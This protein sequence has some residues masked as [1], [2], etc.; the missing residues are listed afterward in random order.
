MN[1]L[2]AHDLVR[3]RRAGR[4][5][6]FVGAIAALAIP[7]ADVSLA[8]SPLEKFRIVAQ[9]WHPDTQRSLAVAVITFQ[10]DNDFPVYEPIIACDFLKPGGQLLGRRGT[11]VHMVFGHGSTKAEGIEFTLMEKD[12]VPG[13]CRVVSVLTSPSA[14]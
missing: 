3:R 10:N 1:S 6:T 5:I 2:L 8:Q 9:E 7:V 13:P 11:N 4:R 14:D 12:A